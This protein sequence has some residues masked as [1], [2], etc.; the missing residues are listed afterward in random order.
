MAAGYAVTLAP[1]GVVGM[2][3]VRSATQR[4]DLVIIDLDMPNMDGFELLGH[5]RAAAET[6]YMPALVVTGFDEGRHTST[7]LDR[8]ANDFI[9]KPVDTRVLVARVRSH[10]GAHREA[11]RWRC[12]SCEDELTGL[13]TRWA[14]KDSARREIGRAV[15]RRGPLAVTFLDLEGFK[16]IN[17]ELG[18]SVGD[19][20]LECV[21]DALRHVLRR[22]DVAARWGGDEFVVA[23]PGAERRTAQ[24]VIER[25][26]EEASRLTRNNLNLSVGISAGVSCLF[27]DVRAKDDRAITKLIDAADQAMYHDKLERTGPRSAVSDRLVAAGRRTWG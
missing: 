9:H 6:R 12:R 19:R 20:V 17:D 7:C 11:Q 13:L 1:D 10:L 18:H 8:G 26:R 4:P 14:F 5:L 24:L 3:F 21:A 16:S 2:H 25:I 22:C 27:D 23:L 15:R